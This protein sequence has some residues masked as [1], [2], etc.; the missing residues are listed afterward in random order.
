MPLKIGGIQVD[1][2]AD[3]L[4]L[5]SMEDEKIC[6]GTVVSKDTILTAAHCT[7]DTKSKPIRKYCPANLSIMTGQ[8]SVRQLKSGPRYNIS[9]IIYPNCALPRDNVFD[10]KCDYAFLK[11]STPMQN[12]KINLITRE[13]YCELM[14]VVDEMNNKSNHQAST[15][16]NVEAQG[17]GRQSNKVEKY[18][19]PR[20]AHTVNLTLSRVS[21]K[22][23]FTESPNN[24]NHGTCNGDSGGPLLYIDNKND[25]YLLG[26]HSSSLRA[27]KDK[28]ECLSGH[29]VRATQ[30]NLMPVMG[31]VESIIS[32]DIDHSKYTEVKNID[33][34][35]CIKERWRYDGI[36]GYFKGVRRYTYEN[37]CQDHVKLEFQK[38]INGIVIKD[39]QKIIV[40]KGKPI[41]VYSNGPIKTIKSNVKCLRKTKKLI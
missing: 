2:K 7:M 31:D 10:I 15:I 8:G 37:K 9:S 25:K 3:H 41:V 36:E 12:K 1:N 39:S 30:V 34:N 17:F 4:V 27:S 16:G 22:Q 23:L 18:S 20:Y 35:G 6:T 19:S 28:S 24:K 5:I 32:N 14:Q 29:G 21:D 38:E 13:K 26:V 33:P 11:T 40:E